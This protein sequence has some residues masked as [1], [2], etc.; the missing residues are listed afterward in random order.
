MR[1]ALISWQCRCSEDAMMQYQDSLTQTSM[2]E[3]AYE[4]DKMRK[5]ARDHFTGLPHFP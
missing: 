2:A 4:N 5:P 1:I 3:R